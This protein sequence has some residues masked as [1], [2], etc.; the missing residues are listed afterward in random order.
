MHTSRTLQ[1]V[2]EGV[3]QIVGRSHLWSLYF[4]KT[5]GESSTAK[6]YHP[7]SLLSVICKIFEKLTNKRIV[8]H[9]EKFGLFSDLQYGFRSSQSTADL[10]TVVSDSQGLPLTMGS[11][12]Y[13]KC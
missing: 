3:F 8:D 6:N 12:N 7:V 1:Y 13:R 11:H 5:V 2:S 9:L 4:F 10:V